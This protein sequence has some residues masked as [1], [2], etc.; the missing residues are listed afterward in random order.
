MRKELFRFAVFSI[1]LFFSVSARAERILVERIIAVVNG[2]IILWSE[3]QA[4]V[5]LMK[6]KLEAVIDP[7]ERKKREK[8]LAREILNQMIDEIL[9]AQ[10]AK[11]YQIQISEKEIQAAIEDTKKRYGL[12]DE[13]FREAQR[14]QGYTPESYRE[15]IRRE[16]QKVKLIQR[17]LQQKVRITES[18]ERAFYNKMVK[19][20]KSEGR[21]FLVKHILI[22]IKKGDTPEAIAEK[23]SL[24]EKILEELKKEPKKFD[25]ILKKYSSNSDRVQGGSLGWMKRGDLHPALESAMLRTEPGKIYPHLLRTPIGFHILAVEKVRRSGILPFEEARANIRKVLQR[26]AFEKAYKQYLAQLRRK[27]VIEIFSK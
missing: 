13:Q 26:R 18:D 6:A 5:K 27:A 11:K 14:Q 22:P 8:K 25:T 15:M 1:F 23:K 10:E 24:A 19:D 4:R 3:W 7:D 21:E 16:L 17:V 9:L 12:T 2:E 20:L